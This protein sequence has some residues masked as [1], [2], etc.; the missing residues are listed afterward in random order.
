[1][2]RSVLWPLGHPDR[3]YPLARG[4][5]PVAASPMLVIPQRHTCKPRPY[6]NPISFPDA[7]F[8]SVIS[9]VLATASTSPAPS[10][11][12]SRLSPYKEYPSC[13][14]TAINTDFNKQRA[15]LCAPSLPPVRM[16][17]TF[18]QENA[19]QRNAGRT[20][21]APSGTRD[22]KARLGSYCTGN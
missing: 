2:T 17:A 22:V 21:L 8:P 5:A 3:G 11:G 6:L 18:K 9:Q 7:S 14:P 16:R 20:R 1:M 15:S 19:E 4:M 13:N 10:E 12:H